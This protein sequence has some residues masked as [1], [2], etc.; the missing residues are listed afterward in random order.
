M[1]IV[2]IRLEDLDRRTLPLGFA[3]EN[4][5]TRVRI[6]CASL[7][8]EYPAALPCLTV[9]PPGGDPYPGV[10]VREGDAVYFVHSYFAD[11][12][13]EHVLA[14]AAYGAELTAAVGMDNVLGCQFHPEK[15]GQVG[16]DILRSFCEMR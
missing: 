1:R 9:S 12:C 15:S 5:R 6:G 8:A 2:D 3:G 16:L 10:A 11:R 13:A 14:T 4:L 7:Y